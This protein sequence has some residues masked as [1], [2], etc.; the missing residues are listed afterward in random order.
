M[1]LIIATVSFSM[2]LCTCGSKDGNEPSLPTQP[3]VPDDNND[4]D[5]EED[6]FKDLYGYWLNAD[7]T[8]AMEIV[9]HTL[10]SCTV[11]YYVYASGEV[12]SNTSECY[13]SKTFAVLTPDGKGKFDVSISSNSQNKIFLEKINGY[14]WQILSSYVFTRVT[15]TEFYNYIE[16]GGVNDNTGTGDNDNDEDD[17][18]QKLLGSWVGVDYDETYT[19]TFYS[20]GKA[21]EEW[22]DGHDSRTAF[23]TYKY[24]NGQITE[25]AIED[26]SILLNVINECPWNVTF[27]SKNTMT[28]KS[29]YARKGMTF[30]KK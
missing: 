26:G 10:A 5:N 24:S 29:V 13:K 2:L 14:S 15:E 20:S 12:K 19:I 28:L 25:W 1:L 6:Y 4:K 7:K 30:T 27:N 21:K 9:K 22:S 16:N 8:G 23:G 3:N 18:V 11:K 17:D